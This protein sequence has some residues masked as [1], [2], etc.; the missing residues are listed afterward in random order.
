M[1]IVCG[2]DSGG[3]LAAEDVQFAVED[4]GGVFASGQG[5]SGKT[6]SI[7][8]IVLVKAG[9]DG[10]GVEKRSVMGAHTFHLRWERLQSA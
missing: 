10:C 4:C 5:G 9:S 2:W 6:L 7:N 1:Y 3:G 8:M